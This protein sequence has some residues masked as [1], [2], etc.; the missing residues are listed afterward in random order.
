MPH[1]KI[2]EHISSSNISK[3]LVK[4][5]SGLK[6][7]DTRLQE[8]ITGFLLFVV[9]KENQTANFIRK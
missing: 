5:W 3:F 1:V 4:I 2:L 6:E 8:G 9:G 7:M